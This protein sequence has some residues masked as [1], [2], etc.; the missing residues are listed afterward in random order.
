MSK[1]WITFDLDGTLMQNPFVSW[2]FPEIRESVLRKT[3]GKVD[4]KETMIAEHNRRMKLNKVVEAYDWDHIL[5]QILQNHHVDLEISIEDL[6]KKHSVIPKIYLLEDHLLE[7]LSRLKRNGY[8]LAIVT[9]GYRKYQQPVVDALELSGLFDC[10]ITP[11]QAGYAKPD[12]RIVSDLL[13]EGKVAAHVGDRIDHDVCLANRLN[14]TSVFISRNLPQEVI[15][16]PHLERIKHPI[17]YEFYKQK[18]MR[19]TGSV[20]EGHTKIELPKMVIQSIEEF[21]LLFEG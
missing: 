9:N 13:K 19:E 2:V 21:S 7:S 3:N 14:I 11:D 4:A 17:F 12:V 20:L 16:Y 10:F 8:R 5:L 1:R 6:V 18:W 15:P